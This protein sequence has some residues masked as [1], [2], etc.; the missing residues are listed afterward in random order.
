MRRAVLPIALAAA[1][2][3]AGPA[4]AVRSAAPSP[5]VVAA[6]SCSPGFTHARIDG[7]QKCLRAGEFCAHRYDHRAPHPW[8]YRHYG[9]ACKHRDSRGDYHLTRR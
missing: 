9:Y 5:R 8:P 2:L 6:R 4:G 3:A 7:A 1:V